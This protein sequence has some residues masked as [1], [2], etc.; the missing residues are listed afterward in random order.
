MRK[1]SVDHCLFK[2]ALPPHSIL[3]LLATYASLS[4]TGRIRLFAWKVVYY[5]HLVRVVDTTLSFAA[6]M[7]LAGYVFEYD[8]LIGTEFVLHVIQCFLRSRYPVRFRVLWSAYFRVV[9]CVSSVLRYCGM[10]ASDCIGRFISA[11]SL[12]NGIKLQLFN[13]H[14]RVG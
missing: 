7:T 11:L 3:P 14:F 1:S 8:L 13:L 2:V 10:S 6:M 9:F 4:V 5:L 12:L